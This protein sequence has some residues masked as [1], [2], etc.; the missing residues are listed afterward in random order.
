MVCCMLACSWLSYI[1][2][3]AQMPNP[4]ATLFSLDELIAL[5]VGSDN[6]ILDLQEALPATFWTCPLS[7]NPILHYSYRFPVLFI[8]SEVANS[9]ATRLCYHGLFIYIF[10]FSFAYVAMANLFI[11]CL[12][13][14]EYICGDRHVAQA[15]NGL[16]PPRCPM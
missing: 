9:V 7:L 4:H 8:S 1:L 15:I 14:T 10:Y 6:D 12:Y 2:G 3:L 5:G 11:Y 16:C 13:Y